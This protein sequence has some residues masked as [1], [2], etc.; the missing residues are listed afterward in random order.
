MKIRTS[1]SLPGPSAGRRLARAFS[2]IEVLVVTGLLS[3][4]IIGL[5]M[6]FAQTQRAY[7]LGMTQ[8]D[9]LE[10]GRMATDLITRD[11]QQLAPAGLP[12]WSGATNFYVATLRAPYQALSQELPGNAVQRS[13]IIQDCFL[14]TR[15]NQTWRGIGYVVR[16]NDPASGYTG[17][18]GGGIGTLYRYGYDV[19]GVENKASVQELR[20]NPALLNDRFALGNWN[21][22]NMSRVLEGVVHFTVR[23][24]DSSGRW[25]NFDHPNVFPGFEMVYPPNQSH[26]NQS[27]TNDARLFSL[28]S[29]YGEIGCYFQSNTIPA[30]VEIELGVLESREIERARAISSPT[31]RAS[32][33]SQQAGK[34]HL[35]RWRV[36]VR[37][38]DPSVYQ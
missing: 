37:N 7:K 15:E 8:V 35:F 20:V 25:I 4:I 17:Y 22:T 36:P 2:L 11:L 31:A 38:A 5:V 13:N 3:V 9:V 33:L 6:M 14:L 19:N 24:Y 18:P 16:T 28:G 26:P 12:T 1:I 23:A 32:Y 10:G 21:A 29:R 34:V 27:V 30:S